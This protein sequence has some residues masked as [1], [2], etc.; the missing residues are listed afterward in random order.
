MVPSTA[1]ERVWSAMDPGLEQTSY[2]RQSSSQEP[3]QA[4]PA[5]AVRGSPVYSKASEVRSL[6]NL[7]LSRELY[8][9][10]FRAT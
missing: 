7:Q 9:L 10:S 2:C 3:Q 8:T 4:P 6:L 5:V 1:G